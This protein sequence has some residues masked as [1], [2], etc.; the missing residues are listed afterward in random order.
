MR[1]KTPPGGFSPPDPW[2]D[3]KNLDDYGAIKVASVTMADTSV[4][5]NVSSLTLTTDNTVTGG[6]AF[7]ASASNLRYLKIEATSGGVNAYSLA[8]PAVA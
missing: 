4:K 7:M 3:P 8:V 2:G 6:I 1:S 5:K